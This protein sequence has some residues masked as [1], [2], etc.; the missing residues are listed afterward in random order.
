MPASIR[1]VID[2]VISFLPG[3]D[4]AH[5]VDLFNEGNPDQTCT[6][7]VSTFVASWEVIQRAAELKC[8][9]I[10]SHEPLYFQAECE[11][12][13]SSLDPIRIAKRQGILQR[14]LVVWRFHD[15]IHRMNPDGITLGVLRRLG[16]DHLLPPS[17]PYIISHEPDTLGQ[18]CT[19]IK[20]KLSIDGIRVVGRDTVICK[21]IAV[22][23]GAPGWAAH[24]QLLMR[25]DVD[26]LITGES[27]E[28]ETYEYVRDAV[29]MGKN[30]ALIVLGHCPSEEYGMEYCAEWLRTRIADLPVH[31]IPA[32]TSYK[33][34]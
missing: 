16:W 12:Y 2:K 27:R 5:T 20:S 34:V 10:I 14:G 21:R 23:L 33:T 4:P 28:W 15:Y 1:H 25:D 29:A 17:R 32:G 3:Y 24:H 31:F 7:L 11:T 9:L 6:G 30:K 13:D 26:V 18:L 22:L 8:N 19:E